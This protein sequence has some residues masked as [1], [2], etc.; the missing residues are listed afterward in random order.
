MPNMINSWKLLCLQMLGVGL[1]ITPAAVAKDTST[2]PEAS[3]S[4]NNAQILKTA[5]ASYNFGDLDIQINESYVHQKETKGNPED[6]YLKAQIDVR[7]NG[8]IVDQLSFDHMQDMGYVAGL[9]LPKP[10]PLSNYFLIVKHGDY[11]GHLIL[12]DKTG[13]IS[14]IAGGSY[15]ITAD[16][17][18]LFSDYEEDTMGTGF[19]VFNLVTNRVVFKTTKKD[20]AWFDNIDQ[21]YKDGAGYFFTAS[22]SD[23]D[24]QPNRKDSWIFAYKFS[25]NQLLREPAKGRLKLA[26]KIQLNCVDAKKSAV[27]SL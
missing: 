12:I 25:N 9:F 1:L 16:K 17:R 22:S 19:A 3:I 13:K 18:S 26:E 4:P 23:G 6:F 15:F 11:D 5:K 21:W 8:A 10:Q 14:K 7:R 2:R 24:A 20:S 27:L